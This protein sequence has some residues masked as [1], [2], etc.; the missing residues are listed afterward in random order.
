VLEPARGRSLVQ[1]LADGR[2]DLERFVRL[3]IAA[4]S[5]LGAVDDRG[6]IQKDIKPEHFFVDDGEA[7]ATLI[8][9]GLATDFQRERREPVQLNRLE[10][11]LA[12]LSPEQTGRMNRSV[13][14]RSDL[15]SLGV[16]LYELLTGK[17]PFESE[18]LLELVHC[19]IARSPLAPA[20][21]RADVPEVLSDILLRL[22]NKAAERRYQTAAGLIA[23]LER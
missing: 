14:R 5:A 7:S 20:V 17:L 22:L 15:Y 10:G 19:H 4:A 2:P 21:H 23:D 6:I 12:Y 9:F 3:A 16:A 1:S 8:D 18:D 11:T 13:D